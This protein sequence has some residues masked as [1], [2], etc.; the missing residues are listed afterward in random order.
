MLR[1]FINFKLQCCVCL[2]CIYARIVCMLAIY[3]C[4]QCM[5]ACNVCVIGLLFFFLN[6]FAVSKW[7]VQLQNCDLL[8]VTYCDLFYSLS[9]FRVNNPPQLLLFCLHFRSCLIL[10][11]FTSSL[12]SIIN[13]NIIN[14]NLLWINNHLHSTTAFRWFKT[15]LIKILWCIF[16]ELNLMFKYLL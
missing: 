3:V 6:S 4:L 7:P 15:F 13:H 1:L 14:Q 11:L 2:E 5:Y 12:Y 8:V 9:Q 10:N 16:D